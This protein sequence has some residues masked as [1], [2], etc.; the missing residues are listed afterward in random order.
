MGETLYEAAIREVKEETGIDT[1]FKGVFGLRELTNFRYGQGDLY[2]PCL[3]EC[4]GETTI[5][6][7]NSELSKCEWLPF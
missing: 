3:M 7:Q 1:I 4:V 2:F 6:M 5:Q